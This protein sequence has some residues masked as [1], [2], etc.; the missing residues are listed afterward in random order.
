MNS[1]EA[2]LRNSGQYAVTDPAEY[3][4]TE[5]SLRTSDVHSL[6]AVVEAPSSVI[7]SLTNSILVSAITNNTS[8][9]ITDNF[10]FNDGQKDNY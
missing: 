4:K 7:S 1:L 8:H 3:S 2:T 6:V 9:N 10:I 5:I